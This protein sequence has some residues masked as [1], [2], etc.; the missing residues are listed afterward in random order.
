MAWSSCSMFRRRGDEKCWRSCELSCIQNPGFASSGLCVPESVGISQEF[1]L[2]WEF[3]V[4]TL[5]ILRHH[6]KLPLQACFTFWSLSPQLC[7][8]SRIG[9]SLNA[10]PSGSRPV[11]RSM[12]RG[13]LDL[14]VV[15]FVGAEVFASRASGT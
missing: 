4:E 3:R 5:A 15:D 10:A 2:T 8:I 13:R 12:R 11:S 14:G 6:E 7:R 1:E 9:G